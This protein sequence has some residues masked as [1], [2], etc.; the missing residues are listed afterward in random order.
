MLHLLI[1]LIG[2]T[3]LSSMRKAAVRFLRVRPWICAEPP[4]HILIERSAFFYCGA[5]DPAGENIPGLAETG[6]RTKR[7]KSRSLLSGSVFGT[8]QH[9]V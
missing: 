3:R 9:F 1:V 7:R 5:I 4:Y 8:P 6:K 2:V